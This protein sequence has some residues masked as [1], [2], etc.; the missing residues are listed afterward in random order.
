MF[1][2]MFSM[3]ISSFPRLTLLSR[4]AQ[5]PLCLAQVSLDPFPFP[6]REK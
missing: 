1:R 2:S 4:L 6:S 5:S 3:T